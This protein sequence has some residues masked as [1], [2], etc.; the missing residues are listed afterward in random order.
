MFSHYKGQSMKTVSD[1]IS[2]RAF[3]HLLA[4]QVNCLNE[5]GLS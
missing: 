5:K 3:Y 4:F 1:A 2:R